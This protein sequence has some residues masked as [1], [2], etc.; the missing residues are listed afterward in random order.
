MDKTYM[1]NLIFHLHQ[2]HPQSVHF[3]VCCVSAF[4]GETLTYPLDIIKTRLQVV[5]QLAP[6]RTRPSLLK[7]TVSIVKNEGLLSFWQGLSP[8][9]YR[10]FLYTGARMPIY[11][12]I[13]GHVFSMPPA[14]NE[15]RKAWLE[16]MKKSEQLSGGN[17][18]SD[19]L[20]STYLWRAA[21]GGV[22]LQTER[23][24][25]MNVIPPLPDV[26]VPHASAKASPIKVSLTMRQLLKEAGFFGL[27]RGG[28]PNVQRAAL[29]NMG[30]MTT[31]DMAKRWLQLWFGLKDGPLLHGCAS[32]MSGF[33][34]A[35]LGTPADLIKTR[36]MNQRL[37]T[38]SGTTLPPLY[39]GMIDCAVKV[40]KQE[41]FLTLYRG[42]FLIWGR[43]APWSLT[44]WLTYEKLREYTGAGGF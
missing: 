5:G 25:T 14:S 38:H 31:Y 34:S 15:A 7:L 28:L 27:W 1:H 42:F 10:H 17:S 19:R 12:I 30:E 6:T 23:R 21:A 39:S 3:S 37:M 20:S 44:F 9:L 41:G 32:T 36:M 4:V 26:A 8:A 18:D 13:R 22:R 29:V 24:K 16:D 43:M 11:E 40:V 35:I 33:V 2:Q